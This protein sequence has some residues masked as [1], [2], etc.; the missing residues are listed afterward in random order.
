MVVYFSRSFNIQTPSLLRPSAD[1]RDPVCPHGDVDT[2]NWG[3]AGMKISASK[4]ENMVI[5]R[6]RVDCSLRAGEERVT[7]NVS[8]DL[9]QDRGMTAGGPSISVL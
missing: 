2:A 5:R 8:Q 7:P 4:S 3:V 6:K 9:D 1:G